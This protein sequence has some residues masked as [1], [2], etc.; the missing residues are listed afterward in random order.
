VWEFLSPFQEMHWDAMAAD[1]M[2][3]LSDSK[4]YAELTLALEMATWERVFEA[5]TQM[6]DLQ[7][8]Q[9]HALLQ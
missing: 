1:Q 6:A 3:L 2:R 7:H 9:M 4:I 8:L 5:Q